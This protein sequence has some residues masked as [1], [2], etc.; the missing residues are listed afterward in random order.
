MVASPVTLPPG[1]VQA[2]DIPRRHG[3]AN[4]REDNRRE[5]ND[6]LYGLDR[7]AAV[8]NQHLHLELLQ[9]ARET[10]KLGRVAIRIALFDDQVL[11]LDVTEFLQT[12]AQGC[13][14]GR[15][16]RCPAQITDARDLDLLRLAK[17]TA[18]RASRLVTT[19]TNVRRSIIES[20]HPRAAAAIGG[21]VM[22]SAFAVL[23]LITNSNLV[24]C[25][26]GRSPGLVPFKILST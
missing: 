7:Q 24:G 12:L 17:S 15:L 13:N 4:N 10:R 25:S 26:T 21:S 8:H 23:R 2:R 22:P 18:H 11:A 1:P 20:P 9:L 3:V 14:V 16:W 6:A 19:R 5:T